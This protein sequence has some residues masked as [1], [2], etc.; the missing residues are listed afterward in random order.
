M[1]SCLSLGFFIPPPAEVIKGLL[2]NRYS[3]SLTTA[4]CLIP[5]AAGVCVHAHVCVLMHLTVGRVGDAGICVRWIGSLCYIC[6]FFHIHS[7]IR[8]PI[9][10]C[11]YT[12]IFLCV[13]VYLCL[14]L[15]LCWFQGNHYFLLHFQTTACLLQ[16]TSS[17][18]RLPLSILSFFCNIERIN[19][20]G[21]LVVTVSFY[22]Y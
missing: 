13:C 12:Y 21:P 16:S 20:A 14:G 22:S 18:S 2:V 10:S 7:F 19:P 6:L 15:A 5:S 4:N 8:S 3:C 1:F 9:N 11:V 17:P